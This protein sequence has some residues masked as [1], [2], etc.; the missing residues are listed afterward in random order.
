MV[1]YVPG[2][3]WD[4]I[5]GSDRRLAEALSEHCRVIWLDPPRSVLQSM[6]TGGPVPRVSEPAPNIVR[7]S[8][9]APPGVTR[10]GIRRIALWQLGRALARYLDSHPA[11]A[12]VAL[13][14]ATAEPVL[15]ALRRPNWKSIYF[16]T[17]DFVAGASLLGGSARHLAKARE[18][19]LRSADIVLAV[20]PELAQSLNRGDR[21][22]HWFPNGAELTRFA[23]IRSI[24]PAAEVSL[25]API[26]G[27]VGQFN[28]RTD[29]DFL[30]AVQ[31]AGISLLLVGPNSYRDRAAAERFRGLTLRQGVQWTG[32]VPPDRLPAFLRTISVG[33]TPYAN[34]LFN[35][36]SYP[37][38]T[39]EY[40]AAGL[41]VVTTSVMPTIGLDLRYVSA[42][43]RPDEFARAVVRV[44]N[45]P[46]DSDAVRASVVGQSW[47]RRAAEFLA[48]AF[49]PGA[50][51]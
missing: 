21:R 8:V 50:Q 35:R 13:I 15:S 46:P 25:D 11:A 7:L 43:S 36:R 49:G 37:L 28:E 34:S 3:D 44:A 39:L 23:A 19:N 24:P 29:V 17:D 9:T 33:L 51:P 27:V 6:R 22:A 2:V 18:S 26:A 20:T 5:P 14:A 4:A 45:D 32:A 40:L 47:A 1:V 10:V 41:P 16:A 30:E 12:D 38:K 48:L 42:V 31:E